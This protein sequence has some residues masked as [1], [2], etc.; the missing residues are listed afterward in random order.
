MQCG[1]NIYQ[2]SSHTG[3]Q[4]VHTRIHRTAVLASSVPYCIH[5]ICTWNGK[6]V[7]GNPQ[8]TRQLKEFA[9][10]CNTSP[11]LALQT[12]VTTSHVSC[13]L[14]RQDECVFWQVWGSKNMERTWHDYRNRWAG[15][16]SGLVAVCNN[17]VCSQQT[18]HRR[19]VFSSHLFSCWWLYICCYCLPDLYK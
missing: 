7:T 4:T 14:T 8:L 2:E 18:S 16:L 15:R 1:N 13:G 3:K 12:S 17:Y 5:K 6:T 10:M 11:K 9:K 19:H